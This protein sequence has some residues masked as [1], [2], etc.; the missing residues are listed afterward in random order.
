MLKRGESNDAIEVVFVFCCILHLFQHETY[1]LMSSA[2][3]AEERTVGGRHCG[4]HACDAIYASQ[5]G[6]FIVH[7][8]KAS[9]RVRSEPNNIYGTWHHKEGKT[10]ENK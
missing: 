9:G 10:S 7:R 2:M 3:A 1:H 4:A 5:P 8:N 6:S